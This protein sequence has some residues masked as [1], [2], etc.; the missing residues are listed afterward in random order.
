MQTRAGTLR[1]GPPGRP[2]ARRGHAC[3]SHRSAVAPPRLAPFL[4]ALVALAGPPARAQHGFVPPDER[5][6][7]ERLAAARVVVI[8]T[9]AEVRTGRIDFESALPV[10]GRVGPEFEVKRAP[11]RP[12]PWIVGDRALLLLAG[13]RSPY[14]WVDRPAEAVTFADT[15]AER[16]FADALRALDAVRV[17]ATARRDLYARWSDGPHEDLA[18]LGHRGLSDAAGMARVMD[19]AFALDRARVADDPERPPAVRRRAARIAARHPAGIAA[20]LE[21]LERTLPVTDAGVAE[22]A[23]QAGL[24][25]GDPAVEARLVQL[26][27]A[28]VGELGALGLRF[29]RLATGPGVERKLSELAIGHPDEAV[30]SE[31]VQALRSLRRKRTAGDG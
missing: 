5:P 9:V 13:A 26:L 3:A 16:R 20:L 24:L 22:V 15:A 31:A 11:S 30:R 10:L 17:D 8:A 27:D 23:I 2:P 25:V 18:A 19:E 1:L 7:H 14:R 28:P 4:L 6:L 12:P 29:A 21:H